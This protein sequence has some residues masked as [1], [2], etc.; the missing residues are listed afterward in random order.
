MRW[1]HLRFEAPLASFGGEAIDARGVIR[2]FPAQSMLTGL[3][4]N[5]LGWT[6]A[7]KTEH[8]ALQDR[9]VFAAAHD[10]SPDIRRLT[11]YQTAQLGKADRAWTTR[12]TPVGRE[13]A[14]S[15]L[16][17]AHQRWRDYHSDL[18]LSLVVRLEPAESTPTLEQLAQ[19]LKRPARPLFL[20]RKPCLPST[21]MFRAWV[22]EADAH[23][24]LSAVLPAGRDYYAMWPP[25]ET[26]RGVHATRLVADERNWASG[27][28]GGARRICTGRVDGRE[29]VR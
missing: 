15:T 11:D 6:R 25:P 10:E 9:I 8:Q 20:G 4:A 22:D 16:A 12:G 7:M 17:G 26:T 1:L 23:K 14:A 3:F 2:D 24:A 13:S 29:R 5:A 18:R 21:A 19:A 27:L 28:H